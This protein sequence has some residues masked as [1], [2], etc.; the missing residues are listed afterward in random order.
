[1]KLDSNEL[2]I[3]GLGAALYYYMNQEEEKKIIVVK[4][5]PRVPTQSDCYAQGK[6]LEP[7]QCPSCITGVSC[8]PCS[9]A[10]CTSECPS[11]TTK[12]FLMS[13]TMGMYGPEQPFA[14]KQVASRPVRPVDGVYSP[15]GPN[16]WNKIDWYKKKNQFSQK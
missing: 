16:A 15:V 3:I 11:G 14:C 12:E 9:S 1:M 4:D 6:I 10:S 13:T 2:V 7:G 8:P 5:K